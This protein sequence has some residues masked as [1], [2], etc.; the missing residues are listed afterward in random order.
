VRWTTLG[1]GWVR[2]AGSVVSWCTHLG[3]EEQGPKTKQWRDH[4]IS[5]EKAQIAT[6][7]GAGPSD[8]IAVMYPYDHGYPVEP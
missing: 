8:V 1:S 6:Y 2:G 4:A 3:S 5:D 7:F